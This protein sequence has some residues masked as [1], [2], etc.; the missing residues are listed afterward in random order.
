[1]DHPCI[2]IFC[3]VGVSIVLSVILLSSINDVRDNYDGET[4]TS[5]ETLKVRRPPPLLV[6]PVVLVLLR[7]RCCCCW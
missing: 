6:L 1:M 4:K 3:T 5:T 7:W 2:I